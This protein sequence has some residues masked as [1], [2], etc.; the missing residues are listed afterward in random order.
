MEWAGLRQVA[1]RCLS[2]VLAGTQDLRNRGMKF[3]PG[4]RVEM[5]RGRVLR[6]SYDSRS[7]LI[8]AN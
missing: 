5:N 2:K 1:V 7:P 3:E 4:R 8:L 6:V